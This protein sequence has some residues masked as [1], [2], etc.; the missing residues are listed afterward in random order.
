MYKPNLNIRLN[1]PPGRLAVHQFL[2]ELFNK[3]VVWRRNVDD[4]TFCFGETLTSSKL[5]KKSSKSIDGQ[6][7]SYLSWFALK[8]V[9]LRTLNW[10][11]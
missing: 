9:S 4:S 3:L 2:I 11:N 5:E 10:R 1:R 8:S 6:M 7:Y